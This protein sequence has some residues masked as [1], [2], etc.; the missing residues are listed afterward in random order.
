MTSRTPIYAY[1]RVSGLGQ[2]ER[3]GFPRQL[4]AVQKYASAHDMR[5]AQVFKEKA[6]PGKTEWDQRP[7]WM[8]MVLQANNGAR[9][10]VIEKLDRL[11]RDLMVQEHIIAD[12]RK[13]GVTLISVAEP[14]LCIDDPSRKVLRQIMGAI[15][16]Y[17]RAMIVLKTRAARDR[18]RAKHGKCEGRKVYGD[19]PGEAAVRDRI[20][21]MRLTQGTGLQAICDTLN[22]EGIPTR[23]GKVWM[24][25]TVRRI[26]RR[27]P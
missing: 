2:V 24:P 5:I 7:E 9:T 12:L 15:A 4:A 18:I 19:K 23:Y 21:K 8:K 3:D 10:I 14:D 16:E 22:A 1:L 26:A 17:D 27:K 20:R 13:R 6:V 11:A 25:M